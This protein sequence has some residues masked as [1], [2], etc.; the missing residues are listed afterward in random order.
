MEI[1]EYDYQGEREERDMRIR[2]KEVCLYDPEYH[3]IQ[4]FFQKE[5]ARRYMKEEEAKRLQQE[6]EKEARS[7]DRVFKSAKMK[8]NKEMAEGSD[9]DFM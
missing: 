1:E 3:F 8:T 7:Y 5:V 6:Q 9:D 2:N 4:P